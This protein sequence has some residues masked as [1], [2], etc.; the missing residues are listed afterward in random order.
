M[1]ESKLEAAML[2]VAGLKPYANNAKVHTEK[3]ITHIAKS[4]RE[5]GFNDP[6]DVWV[7]DAGEY[8]IVAG[9]GAWEAAKLLGLEEIP[10]N[11]LGHLSDEQRRAYC[12]IHNQLQRE[13]DFDYETLMDEMVAIDADWKGFGFEGF[14]F[15]ADDFGTDFALD[16]GD[17]PKEKQITMKLTEEQYNI[18]V[19]ACDAVGEPEIQAGNKYGNL[20]CEVCRQWAER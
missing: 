14:A 17:S 15:D 11:I 9:H 20:V 4:I 3:Q 8:E 12:H 10:C 16:D 5:Y 2:P 7:N 19:S 13:T 18:I 1:Q 6:V